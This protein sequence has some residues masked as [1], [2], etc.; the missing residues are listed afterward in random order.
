MV[1]HTKIILALDSSRNDSA[2][3]CDVIVLVCF[4]KFVLKIHHLV[5]LKIH[6]YFVGGCRM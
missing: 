4:E 2:S 6:L 1:E 5:C 3:V